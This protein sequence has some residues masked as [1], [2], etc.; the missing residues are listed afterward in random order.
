M[1]VQVLDAVLECS[2]CLERLDHTSRVLPCQHTFCRRCLD[3]IVAKR[4]ELRCPECRVLVETKVE[5]LPTNILLI[6]LLEGIKTAAVAN[7]L[8]S[9]RAAAA[10][11]AA[12]ASGGHVT[13]SQS[14]VGGSSRG[15][16]G[17]KVSFLWGT[18]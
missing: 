5:E 14:A 13:G 4:H 17:H 7:A 16:P 2:V 9:R 12:A 11:A 10:A 18:A 1:D 3:E 8:A 15:S 6:R